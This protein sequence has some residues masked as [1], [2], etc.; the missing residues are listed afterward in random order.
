VSD[1]G[2]F[3]LKQF[4]VRPGQVLFVAVLLQS[5]KTTM[6]PPSPTCVIAAT[7]K[8]D[9][10][11]PDAEYVC[12]KRNGTVI[13]DEIGTGTSSAKVNFLI[14]FKNDTPLRI[15]NTTRK[16]E[17]VSNAGT[18]G[19]ERIGSNVAADVYYYSLTCEN[20]QSVD[21]MIRVPPP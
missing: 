12:V 6:P 13:W 2:T 9:C 16:Y 5:C 7:V 1:S 20:G 11:R 21:P 4:L 8:V 19:T 15:F 18:S 14:R 3:Q 10:S 17:V